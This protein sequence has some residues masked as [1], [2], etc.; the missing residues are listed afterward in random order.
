MRTQ[1]TAETNTPQEITKRH[2]LHH[3]GRCH[4]RGEDDPALPAVDD[5]MVVVA[6][7]RPMLGSH[8]GGIGVGETD[9]EVSRA[10]VRGGRWPLRIQV[11]LL[12]QLP[13]ALVRDR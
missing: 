2:I 13:R 4:E 9:A 7:S 5:V 11:P 3:I 10:R 8:R 12:E 6:Q 1:L